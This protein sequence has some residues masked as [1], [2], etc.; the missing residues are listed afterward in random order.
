MNPYFYEIIEDYQLSESQEEK[1][2]ILND[3]YTSL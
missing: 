1:E 3:F 2:E